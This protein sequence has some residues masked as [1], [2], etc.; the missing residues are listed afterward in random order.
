MEGAGEAYMK[1]LL[2]V[3][4]RYARLLMDAVGDIRPRPKITILSPDEEVA[5]LAKNL[6]VEYRSD[7]SI[8]KL[9]TSEELEEYDLAIIAMDDDQD[10]AALVRVAKSMNIPI[11]VSVLNDTANRDLL[12]REGVTYIIDIND[13]AVN[14]IKSVV[15]SDTWVAIK[16]PGTVSLVVALQRIVRRGILGVTLVEVEEAIS[17][18]NAKLILLD[19]SGRVI[20]DSSRAIETGNII[21]LTGIENDVRNAMNRIEKVFRRHEEIFARRYA[22]TLRTATRGYG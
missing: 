1:I 19:S 13:F 10:N 17:G 7:L 2:A 4:K 20:A 5:V 9:Y 12:L 16:V 21:V 8:E 18:S 15:L 22:E 6:G 3:N 14:S 11:I